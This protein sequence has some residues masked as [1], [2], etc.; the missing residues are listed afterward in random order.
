[1]SED[2]VDVVTAWRT[3]KPDSLVLVIPKKL[4]RLGMFEKGQRFLVKLDERRRIIYEAISPKGGA[5]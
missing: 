3:G 5:S 1:M 4:R 2:I